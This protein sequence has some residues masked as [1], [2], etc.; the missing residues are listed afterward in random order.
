MGLTTLTVLTGEWSV[1]SE[2]SA[3]GDTPAKTDKTAGRVCV[4]IK[5]RVLSVLA[6]L[7]RLSATRRR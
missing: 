2:W 3:L 4:T 5:A 7:S 1:R 6:R